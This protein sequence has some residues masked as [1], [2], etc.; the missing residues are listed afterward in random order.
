MPENSDITYYR[1]APLYGVNWTMDQ[2]TLF[3]FRRC[4]PWP[5][6]FE[7]ARGFDAIFPL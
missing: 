5:R 4:Y 7:R 3:L 2:G 6:I 1:A